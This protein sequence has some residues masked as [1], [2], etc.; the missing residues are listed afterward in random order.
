M[1][2]LVKNIVHRLLGAGGYVVINPSIYSEMQNTLAE[3]KGGVSQ[4]QGQL[5]ETLSQVIVLRNELAA[6]RECLAETKSEVSHGSPRYADL[7]DLPRQLDLA[8]TG[9]LMADSKAS[10]VPGE[11]RGLA[12]HYARLADLVSRYWIARTQS[13]A[14]PYPDDDMTLEYSI[15]ADVYCAADEAPVEEELPSFPWRQLCFDRDCGVLLVLGQSNAANHGDTRYTSQYDVYSL[16]VL[17][18]RC[19]RAADPLAGATGSGGS[20][21]SRLGDMLIETGVFRRVLL[22][23]LAFGESFIKDWSP[24]G[25]MHRRTALALSRLRKE[26]GV[27]VLPFSAVLWQ[28]GEAE[29]NRSQ[30]SARSYKM[31]FHDL[32]ADLRAN[33]VFAPVFAACATLCEGDSHPY[34]NRTPIRQALLELPDPSGGIFPGPDT[35]AIGRED[36]FDGYHFS[37]NGLRRCAELWLG[38]LSIC[39][40]PLSRKGKRWDRCCAWSDAVICPAFGA[41]GRDSR[42][43]VWEFADRVQITRSVLEAQWKALVVPAP[44]RRLLRHTLLPLALTSSRSWSAYAATAGAL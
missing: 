25:P 40:R 5:G 39:G 30:M 21:W 4:M 11:S 33:G 18:M 38:P 43:P 14:D 6:A 19:V 3:T 35:D 31:R 41:A 28:Q 10:E 1:R 34:Q 7:R 29:A 15:A 16:D 17:R 42:R 27:A 37:E 12:A 44:S 32:V 8:A 36:R 22:V 26:L 2:R 23:P 9:F 24:E 13:P 20:V